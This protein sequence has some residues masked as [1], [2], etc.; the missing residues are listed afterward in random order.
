MD[1][2]HTNIVLRTTS[3]FKSIVLVFIV[4]I[5]FQIPQHSFTSQTSRSL[6]EIN[7]IIFPPLSVYQV[8]QHYLS[9]KS[10]RYTKRGLHK[11][12]TITC[13]Q[14]INLPLL[15]S[16]TSLFA[17]EDLR[18]TDEWTWSWTAGRIEFLLRSDYLMGRRRREQKV[19]GL[20]CIYQQNP[21]RQSPQQRP[22]SQP[23]S[24]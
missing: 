18:V 7:A 22:K 21:A 3:R 11:L 15:I 4:I 12:S 17:T 2:L 24:I 19:V 5:S 9:I 1:R 8:L 20:S 13:N 23:G 16:S 10:L 14:S 6:L